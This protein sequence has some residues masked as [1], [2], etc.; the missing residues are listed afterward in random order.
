MQKPNLLLLCHDANRTRE[1]EGAFR[2]KYQIT[3]WAGLYP[4]SAAHS[5]HGIA[6]F[7]HLDAWGYGQDAETICRG[8]KEQQIAPNAPK[9]YMAQN[10]DD[11]S[12]VKNSQYN[13]P[14][15]EKLF[16]G[17]VDTSYPNYLDELA[18]ILEHSMFVPMKIGF[19]SS[20]RL[21]TGVVRTF[22]SKYPQ[23][24]EKMGIVSVAQSPGHTDEGIRAACELGKEDPRLRVY[25]DSRDWKSNLKDMLSDSF[26]VILHTS[27]RSKGMRI[28]EGRNYLWEVDRDVVKGVTEAVLEAEQSLS[29]QG[30]LVLP[31]HILGTNPVGL[32]MMLAHVLG[33]PRER[34]S[35]FSYVDPVRAIQWIRDEYSR[36]T[37]KFLED[38]VPIEASVVG[39]HGAEILIRNSIRINGKRPE[40]L[41]FNYDERKAMAEIRDISKETAEARERT[42]KEEKYEL[43][44]MQSADA[45]CR[46][47]VEIASRKQPTAPL[48]TIR[49]LEGF[50][51]GEG[52]LGFSSQLG[53]DYCGFD[54]KGFALQDHAVGEIL[55]NLT[56]TEMEILKEDVYAESQYQKAS[57]EAY[58]HKSN[59]WL[60]EHLYSLIKR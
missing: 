2:D 47:C 10:R 55:P 49:S 29:C 56:P 34:L 44:H 58:L 24:I 35:G 5:Y 42:R 22:Y 21:T 36:Q 43:L 14:E 37:G 41:G 7:D 32:N 30:N 27:S 51:M 12:R 60:K 1:I 17:V 19:I 18:S 40:E 9:I 38:S 46:L 33:M 3:A 11:A 25:E 26:D 54:G 48:Y 13:K 52:C 39:Q 31:F 59:G 15:K 50:M 16:R 4:F 20:G 57:L 45:F 28:K 8:L 23:Y 53:F 6:V